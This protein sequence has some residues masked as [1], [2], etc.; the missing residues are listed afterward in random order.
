[1]DIESKMALTTIVRAIISAVGDDPSRPGLAGTPDRVVRAW[2]ELCAGYGYAREDLVDMLKLFPREGVLVGAPE[3]T[4]E[5]EV[6]NIRFVSMC[7]HHMMP[8]SGTVDVWYLAGEALIGLSKIPRVVDLLARKLQVQERLSQEI[9]DV[10]SQAT[11][12][13]VAVTVR[14]KHACLGHRGH[15]DDGVE[16]VT[17][18]HSG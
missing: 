10:I 2:G 6:N 17:H 8:F 13:A 5:V 14:A 7:E 11:G 15:R 1:M 4:R 12:G 18:G 3:E 16:M 9:A